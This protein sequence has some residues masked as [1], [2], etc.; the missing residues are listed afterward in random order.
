MTL[1]TCINPE[2]SKDFIPRYTTQSACSK[3]CSSRAGYLRRYTPPLQHSYK[4][5]LCGKEGISSKKRRFCS[6]KC[7]YTVLNKKTL[8]H[9]FRLCD[10]CQKVTYISSG[11]FC[12]S[13]NKNGGKKCLV[14]KCISCGK[15]FEISNEARKRNIYCSPQCQQHGI[16]IKC[17][18]QSQLR[19]GLCSWCTNGVDRKMKVSIGEQLLR[20]RVLE[21]YKHSTDIRFNYRPKW[22]IP[23]GRKYPLELDVAVVDLKIGFEFDGRHHIDPMHKGY[24][25]TRRRDREKTNLCVKNDWVLIRVTG[26]T[27]VRHQSRFLSIL[28]SIDALH[29]EGVLTPNKHHKYMYVSASNTQNIVR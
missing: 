6:E 4:C 13:C 25:D 11:N 18:H 9:R 12:R 14:G 24:N 3:K 29:D 2:C 5:E 21:T 19:Q 16:C 17:G 8:M 10:G 1:K 7:A 15:E 20:Q 28:D 23:D 27:P 22:L 26:M